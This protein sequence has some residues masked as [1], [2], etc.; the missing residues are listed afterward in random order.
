MTLPP[1]RIG[2]GGQRYVVQTSGWPKADIQGWQNAAYSA[3]YGG[4]LQLTDVFMDCP[5]CK[6]TQIIDRTPGEPQ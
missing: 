1:E 5:G 3:T 4:A 2:D 6:G